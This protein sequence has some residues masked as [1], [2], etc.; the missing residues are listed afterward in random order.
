[1]FNQADMELISRDF[2]NFVNI[3]VRNGVQ[4]GKI[5]ADLGERIIE[6]AKRNERGIMEWLF[7]NLSSNVTEAELI[8]RARF[9]AN[10]I[11]SILQSDGRDYGYN[12]NYA[13]TMNMGMASGTGGTRIRDFLG[14]N[15]DSSFVRTVSENARAE[16]RRQREGDYS[17]KKSEVNNGKQEKI[18]EKAAG[19]YLV[20]D[21]ASENEIPVVTEDKGSAS[22][23]IETKV[24]DMYN[25]TDT[26]MLT[27]NNT[28]KT[29]IAFV[30]LNKPVY[31][32]KDAVASM[33]NARPD[34]FIARQYCVVLTY[35]KLTGYSIPNGGDII[36]E[37]GNK[38]KNI[39]NEVT[40]IVQLTDRFEPALTELP[41][42]LMDLVNK[43]YFTRLNTI[44]E[45]C[46][47]DYDDPTLHLKVPNWNRMGLFS[48]V[49]DVA[50]EKTREK[51]LKYI[52]DMK[53]TF[54]S[55]YDAS[56]FDIAKKSFDQTL[57]GK[58]GFIDIRKEE[59]ECVPVMPNVNITLDDRYFLRDLFNMPVEDQIRMLSTVARNYLVHKAEK[60]IV[61]TNMRLSTSVNGMGINIVK[62]NISELL[63]CLRY[64][65][66]KVNR[67]DLM[68]GH[69]VGNSNV[70][71]DLARFGLNISSSNARGLMKIKR[72]RM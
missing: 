61:I 69:Y 10:K 14:E 37:K 52:G 5:S 56:V 57:C 68:V 20:G 41:K 12:G 67:T 54:G 1:M 38:F 63:N 11:I 29:N 31:N 43:I 23:S 18:N 53:N 51:L 45:Y 58:N 32:T 8:E 49:Q 9:C 60:T 35:P 72:E 59:K 33:R 36:F 27:Q 34:L 42:P 19:V 6:Y 16:E 55:W 62:N 65:V 40:G 71:S 70:P 50:D 30:T 46:L 2:G 39:T 15:R 7:S 64:I 28:S 25:I 48:T 44:V 26:C 21:T 17:N 13:A 24:T 66:D 3:H 22:G 47:W 4:S